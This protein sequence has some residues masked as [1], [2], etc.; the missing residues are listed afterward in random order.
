MF[1]LLKRLGAA[2]LLVALAVGP[3]LAA[4]PV[5]DLTSQQIMYVGGTIAYNSAD[6]TKHPLNAQ[7]PNGATVVSVVVRVTTAFNAATT[8]TLTVG[9]NSTSYNNLVAAADVNAGVVGNTDVLS[10]EGFTVTAD[11]Q[12]YANYA[13]TGTAATAGAATIIV[14]YVNSNH[15]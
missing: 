11:T 14:G 1:T 4:N 13:Q 9:S 3:A 10:A 2:A 15:L 8:N 12:L 7:I 6:A 5:R